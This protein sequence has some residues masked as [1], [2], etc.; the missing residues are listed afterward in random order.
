MTWYQKRSKKMILSFFVF[1]FIG[2]IYV[3]EYY[4]S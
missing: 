4:E 2:N 1:L 3:K